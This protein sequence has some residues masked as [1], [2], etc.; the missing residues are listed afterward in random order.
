[1]RR[2]FYDASPD[3]SYANAF[4]MA[5]LMPAH[6]VRGIWP[7]VHNVREMARM[8]EV[9]PEVMERRLRDLEIL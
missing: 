7:H 4:A 6:H 3:E 9:P 1:M 8:F 5:L 2:Y